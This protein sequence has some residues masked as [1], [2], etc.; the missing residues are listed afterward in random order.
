[1]VVGH[2]DT[3]TSHLHLTAHLCLHKSNNNT[4]LEAVPIWKMGTVMVALG[5]GL[6]EDAMGLADV[7]REGDFLV[8]GAVVAPLVVGPPMSVLVGTRSSGTIQKSM[9]A[10]QTLSDLLLT[11]ASGLLHQENLEVHQTSQRWACGS[12]HLMCGKTLTTEA[13]AEGAHPEAEADF[14]LANAHL[15]G[16]V[17]KVLNGVECLLLRSGGEGHVKTMKICHLVEDALMGSHHVTLSLPSKASPA[18]HRHP[19]TG[20]EKRSPSETG[21]PSSQ[22]LPRMRRLIQNLPRCPSRERTRA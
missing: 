12:H 13:G 21:N 4:S 6:S 16:L 9:K 10:A 5:A 22:R 1:M 8:A 7:P 3:L 20:S 15:H 18:A 11:R 17:M 14:F 2:V 19:L